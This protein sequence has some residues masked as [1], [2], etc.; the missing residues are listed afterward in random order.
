MCSPRASEEGDW[1][2]CLRGTRSRRL[3]GSFQDQQQHVEARPRPAA[4]TKNIKWGLQGASHLSQNGNSRHTCMFCSVCVFPPLMCM[5]CYAYV[6][7]YKQNIT[8]THTH[9]ITHF[10]YVNTTLVTP[11]SLPL[12]YIHTCSW[13]YMGGHETRGHDKYIMCTCVC[14]YMFMYACIM[15]HHTYVNVTH[16]F[17]SGAPLWV[18]LV[19]EG[20]RDVRYSKRPSLLG[21]AI[22]HDYPARTHANPHWRPLIFPNQ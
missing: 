7:L 21:L 17:C 13:V 18:S 5:C 1:H 22:T 12:R 10:I 19:S 8:H 6:M 2:L 11:L 20:A 3:Q 4:L 15:L 16:L 14:R 9:E